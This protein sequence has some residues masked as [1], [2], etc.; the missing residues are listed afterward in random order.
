MANHSQSSSVLERPASLTPEIALSVELMLKDRKPLSACNNCIRLDRAC[1]SLRLGIPCK[2]CTLTLHVGCEF[3]TLSFWSLKDEIDRTMLNRELATDP[4]KAQK[5]ANWNNLAP[6]VPFFISE[7]AFY[8][9][10]KTATSITNVLKTCDVATLKLL[11]PVLEA[12]AP[13]GSTL[14]SVA[15]HVLCWKEY[16]SSQERLADSTKAQAVA[17]LNRMGEAYSRM[18]GVD[19]SA[20]GIPSEIVDD[21]IFDMEI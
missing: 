9:F 15:R 2:E 10:H 16:T 11:V 7:T 1:T 13:V 12:K 3:A 20:L 8:D 14:P 21:T 17:I 4:S 18:I 6:F 19:L 5:L